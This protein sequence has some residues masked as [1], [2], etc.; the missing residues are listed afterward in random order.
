LNGTG[1]SFRDNKGKDE[2]NSYGVAV[3]A[4]FQRCRALS[5]HMAV[6]VVLCHKNEAEWALKDTYEDEALN[7]VDH[8][9]F[10]HHRVVEGDAT[11]LP[12]EE[13]AAVEVPLKL[14]M[15]FPC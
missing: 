4:V 11:F 1:G 9:S 3:E 15:V 12:E 7:S 2:G 10:V 14:Q 5:T 13:V 6:D 8:H